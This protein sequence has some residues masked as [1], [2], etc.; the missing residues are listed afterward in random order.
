MK[1][2][3]EYRK[4]L[5]SVIENKY[6]DEFNRIEEYLNHAIYIRHESFTSFIVDLETKDVQ[7]FKEILKNYG[8]SVSQE[9][10]SINN[11]FSKVIYKIY[12]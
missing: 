7:L 10:E 3:E 2:A 1:T 11:N 6:K 12:F 5:L 9:I 4:E 8:Y